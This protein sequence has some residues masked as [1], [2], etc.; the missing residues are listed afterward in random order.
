MNLKEMWRLIAREQ[1]KR[2]WEKEGF[3]EIER[4]CEMCHQRFRKLVRSSFAHRVK[5]C[6]QRCAR[7]AAYL[8]RRSRQ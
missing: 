8:R 6:S 5:Y 7:R 4:E 2:R 3:V 1:A